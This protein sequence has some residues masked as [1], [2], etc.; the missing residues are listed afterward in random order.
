M[1]DLSL[2]DDLV[3]DYLA[4]CRE[5]LTTI[6][7]DLLAI[8]QAGAAIDEQLVNRVFR[9][10]HSIKGGAGFFDLLKI[11][12]LAHRTENVL[13]LVRS[14]Q[15]IPNSEIVSILLLAFDKLRSLILDYATSNEADI[16]EFTDALSRLA[17]E[18][19]DADQKNSTNE[20]VAILIPHGSRTITVSAFDLEQARRGGKSVY[21]L[22]YDLIHDIQR[23]GKTPLKV[24]NHLMKCGDILGTEFDLDSAGTL[25]DEPSNRLLLDVLFATVLDSYSLGQIVDVLP[26]RVH[27]I[28]NNCHIEKVGAAKLLPVLEPVAAPVAAAPVE[29]ILPAAAEHHET[30][31]KPVPAGQTQQV[32]TTVRLNVALLDSLMTLAG[33]LVLGRNQLNEA[34][35]NGDKEGIAAGA[36][37][38]SLVTSEL[39]GAVSLT[40]MQPVASLFAKF[41]RLVRDLASELGK[42]VQLK[43]EGGDVELDKTIL[44]GLSDPLTHMVRN[45]VDHGIEPPAARIAA[46][47]PAL[48]TVSLAARH[49]AG[50]VVIE[51]SD[52]G[53]GL[54]GDK[55][56]ASA[57]KK[58]MIT[59]EQLQKMTDYEKQELIFMPGVSTAE[60]LSNVSGRGVGMDVVK[61]NLDRLGGKV[62]IDSVP[63]RGSAFRIK[64]PLTLAII[65]SLLVSDSG[66][67]FAIPQVSVGELIRIP[68][69]QI[70]ERT[71]RAGDAELVL[72]RDRLVPMVYLSDAL[73]SA[74]A[75][76]GSR[77]LNI[78]L[79][80]TGTIEYGLVV[81]DL[82]DTVEIVVK[83][84]GR[85]LQGLVEYAG[86]TILGDGQVAVIL[87]VAGLAARAGLSRGAN[88]SKTVEAGPDDAAGEM[89]SLLLFQNAPGEDCA[90]PIE[91]VTRIERI[92]VA[93][94]ENLGGRRTMQYG[95]VSLPLVALHDVAEVDELVET[96]QWVV[97][98]FDCAG[99]TLGLLAAE[100]LDMLETRVVM[101]TATLRQPGVAGSALL[102]GRTTLMLDIFELANK[103]R[104]DRP[105]AH[106][107]EPARAA[108]SGNS[109]TVLVAEDSDFFRGQIK[110]LIEG[111]GYKVLTAEDGQSA[112]ETLE[113]HA[114]EVS[115]VTTDIEMPRLDGLG[116]TKRI[117]A[118]SRF[119]RLPVIA[120]S[121][122]ASEEE[123]AH[124]YAMGVS[125]YQVKLDQD[126]LLECIGKALQGAEVGHGR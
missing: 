55:I 101:D 105:E 20:T 83:P 24:L 4:E 121:T 10:A 116:L 112:W 32:E 108:R 100:P 60:K 107:F 54:A 39:Q 76:R 33:E 97:V 126:L 75:E 58:G 21:V 69:N 15:M 80:D 29:A 124:G 61:T 63:G 62:E 119:A 82:H 78:V 90:V 64:L 96:Q 43:L 53:Q 92:R 79:V 6:E 57:V 102:N 44:E 12:E 74:R 111:V 106:T 47:K 70:E 117:R 109:A 9:A 87:D 98:V 67:R 91:L 5:H 73:G 104:R 118:D 52:D 71:D 85:H 115:L 2:E 66:E 86:A 37:R 23:R 11:K 28:E 59:A 122:L 50:Q 99:Q 56:G 72:L 125:D 3:H 26:E 17:E 120:L 94:V 13:D 89:R 84:L 35:R 38:V 41:P 93:Q 25:E 16:S 68:A 22:E 18:H 95:G 34:V 65:P 77:A 123:M 1:S 8:E 19:L 88:V 27:T 7:T 40:R 48:G 81:A 110:R 42:E 49:Q 36:Y 31:L 30:A 45:S 14:R 114:S 51:I 103:F 113:S 46:K